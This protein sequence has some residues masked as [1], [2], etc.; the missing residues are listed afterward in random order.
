MIRRIKQ[1]YASRWITNKDGAAALIAIVVITALVVLISISYALVAIGNLEIGFSAQ[2]SGDVLLSAES[3]VEETI[4]RLTRDDSYSGGTL[5]VGDVSCTMTVVGTPCGTCTI[6]AEASAA[7]FT[8]NIQADV[9]ISG[10]SA[11][12]TSWQEID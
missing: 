4:L 6:T 5:T 12:I 3:C 2:R 9:D 7:G 10:G 1:R 8:R 11:D